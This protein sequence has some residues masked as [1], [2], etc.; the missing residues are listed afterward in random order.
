MLTYLAGRTHCARARKKRATLRDTVNS[1]SNVSRVPYCS[2]AASP[3]LS[4]KKLN[5]S[6]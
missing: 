1:K 3:Y 2:G 5:R 6:R 4:I